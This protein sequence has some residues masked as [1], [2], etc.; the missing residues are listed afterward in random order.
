MNDDRKIKI[1]R[2]EKSLPTEEQ[3]PSFEP[4]IK[5]DSLVIALLALLKKII[6]KLLNLK[7]P[8]FQED[9]LYRDL[10][11]LKKILESL[12][13]KDLSQDKA[14]LNYFAL[15][16]LQCV[17]HH[18][19]INEEIAKKV[20][21]VLKMISNYPPD[22]QFSLG[23]YLSQ[24]AGH[25]WLPFPYMNLLQKLHLEFVEKKENSTLYTWIDQLNNIIQPKNGS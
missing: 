8:P 3:P 23:Y 12:A 24:F 18:K 2:I 19:E 14:F 21:P 11:Q 6:N 20:D 16:W 1:E 15:I 17:K 4:E 10:Q 7:P 13:Q 5:E 9:P 25:K 22:A